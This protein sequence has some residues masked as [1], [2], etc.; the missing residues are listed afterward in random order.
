MRVFLILSALLA[1]I[2]LPV[3]A[4][5]QATTKAVGSSSPFA[6]VIHVNDLGITGF[7]LDQR[8]RFLTMLRAPGDLDALAEE[9]LI[10]DRLRLDAAKKAGINVG[11]PA[12]EAGMAEFASRANL[13]TEEMLKTLGQAG[14]EPQTFRDFVEAGTVWREVV[15]AKFANRVKITEAEIDRALSLESERGRGTR[16]LMSEIIIP[17]PPGQEAGAMATAQRI[18]GLRG[19]A[20]FAAAARASSASGSRS[21]GGRLPWMPVENLPAPLRKVVL[22]LA[23]GEASAPLAIPNAVAIFMLRAL[24]ENGPVT[25]VQQTI[26]FAQVLIPGGRSEAALAAAGAL[27][28][29]VDTCDDLYGA[30]KGY[31]PE[32]LL[33]ETLPLSQIPQ[34]IALELAHLD[35]G[36]SSTALV[37]GNALVFLMLC[38]RD[39]LRAEDDPAP[40]RAQIRDSLLNARLNSYSESYMAD[41]LAD[42]V[43]VRP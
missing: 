39:R 25:E 19:E 35:P 41:L 23:P 15:R 43:I 8:K 33:R 40:D 5:A 14:I 26:D 2:A 30:A 28:N 12:V 42:A 21:A 17:A 18:S 13:T 11:K 1:L 10:E 6:P 16:V 4:R 9:A 37:R 36:E 29:K 31:P 20:A 38:T 24:D 22:G 27:R 7:E 3:A 34:D 32:Q